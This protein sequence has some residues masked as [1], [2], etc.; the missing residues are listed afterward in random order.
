MSPVRHLA[1][2]F[3]FALVAGAGISAADAA[4]GLASVKYQRP[5]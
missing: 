2:V 4:E 5:A 3:A 1:G